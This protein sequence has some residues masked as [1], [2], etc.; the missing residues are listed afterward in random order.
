MTRTLERPGLV[1][2]P[3]PLLSRWGWRLPDFMEWPDRH[4]LRIEEIRSDG[5]LTIRAEMPGIDPASDVDIEVLE[6]VLTISAERRERHEDTD[7][8]AYRSEFHYGSFMRQI[9]LPVGCTPDDI[10]ATYTDGILE[11]RV[12]VDGEKPRAQHVEVRATTS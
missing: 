9:Q 7:E 1:P 12:P 11:V 4:A 3:F 5:T 8:G 10:E 2:D 6:G